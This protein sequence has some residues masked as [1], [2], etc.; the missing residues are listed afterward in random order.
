MFSFF[1]ISDEFP[2]QLLR[3]KFDYVTNPECQNRWSK[4]LDHPDITNN[5]I[6]VYNPYTD[7]C[8]GDSGQLLV[9][10]T[11][12]I[13]YNLTEKSFSITGSPLMMNIEEDGMKQSHVIG[14]ASFTNFCDK[15]Q[16]AVYVRVYPYIDW[17]ISVVKNFC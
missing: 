5:N 2:I 6:C 15:T 14:V 7:I 16:P 9:L 4:E 11:N 10:K 12:L 1:N 17:I 13:I 3:T 8:G